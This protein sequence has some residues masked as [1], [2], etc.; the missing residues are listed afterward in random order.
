M[1]VPDPVE[2]CVGIPCG[3]C[4]Q[5][6]QI[7]MINLP[8]VASICCLGCGHALPLYLSGLVEDMKTASQILASYRRRMIGE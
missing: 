7:S 6:L 8:P 4:G 1:P 2:G 5:T 3:H